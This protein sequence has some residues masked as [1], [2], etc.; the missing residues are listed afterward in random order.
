MSVGNFDYLR[1]SNATVL[2]KNGVLE[3]L[4]ANNA[5]LAFDASGNFLGLVVEPARTN[6]LLRSEEFD[7]VFWDKIQSTITS[8]SGISPSGSS[9]A[10][11]WIEANGAAVTPLLLYAISITS[12]IT[13][14]QTIYA[15]SSNR[16]LQITGSTGFST[17]AFANFNL[18]NGTVSLVSGGASAS[19]S[20]VGDEWYRCIYTQTANSSSASGRLALFIVNSPTSTRGQ[21]YVGNGVSG[22][23]IWGAQLEAGA[24]PTSYIPTEASTVTR[25]AATNLKSG[26]SDRVGQ[27]EG[28][29]Y[30]Q[31]NTASFNVSRTIAAL[32]TDANNELKIGKT[33]TGAFFAS[34]KVGGTETVNVINATANRSGDFKLAAA[35]NSTGM[36]LFINGV[37]GGSNTANAVTGFNT[38]SVGHG[39]AAVEQFAEPISAFVLFKRRLGTNELTSLTD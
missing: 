35:Y 18:Q 16:I 31:V 17:A 36:Q 2:N 38:V 12:G 15:K 21:A 3:T 10:D 39:Q 5:P 27:A 24:T 33:N 25:T 11:L 7:N 14:T 1:T 28:T 13:Y 19:I 22:I 26:L 20:S 30:A 9:T 8:N 34:Y 23:L 32:Y 29:I 6:L 37:N 4:T